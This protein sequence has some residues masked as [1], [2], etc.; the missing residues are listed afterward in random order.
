MQTTNRRLH[1]TSVKNP[2]ITAGRNS[3]AKV[4]WALLIEIAKLFPEP[5]KLIDNLLSRLSS[6]DITP[7]EGCTR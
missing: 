3:N 7:E 4:G 2:V 1:K 6:P 5:A